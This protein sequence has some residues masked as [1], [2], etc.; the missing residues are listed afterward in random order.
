MAKNF[1]E[2]ILKEHSLDELAAAPN[3]QRADKILPKPERLTQLLLENSL[4]QLYRGPE[5]KSWVVAKTGEPLEVECLSTEPIN[6]QGGHSRAKEEVD[7]IIKKE[8]ETQAAKYQANAYALS[9]NELNAHGN[10]VLS[11]VFFRIKSFQG[12]SRS[13]VIESSESI[14]KTI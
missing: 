8:V 11:V 14:K 4:I 7:S 12:D 6:I 5:Y 3:N 9:S 10:K 13:S 1:Y 2:K